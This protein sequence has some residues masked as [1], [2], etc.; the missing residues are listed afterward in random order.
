MMLYDSLEAC[1]IHIERKEYAYVAVEGYLV[2]EKLMNFLDRLVFL[3]T[4]KT[5]KKI[6]FDTSKLS[7]VNKN[8]VIWIKEHVFPALSYC[9][10]EKVAFLMPENPFGAL[11][12]KA[13]II[14]TKH[15]TMKIFNSMEEAEKWIFKKVEMQQSI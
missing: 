14:E 5:V 4:K 13:L 1:I 11:A 6:F 12:L 2:T 15:A 8:D 3:C 9:N 10:I 7:V